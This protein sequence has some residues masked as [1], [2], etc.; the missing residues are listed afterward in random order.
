MLDDFLSPIVD[1][2]PTSIREICGITGE[3]RPLDFVTKAELP[4][5]TYLFVAEGV[6][7]WF[8]YGEL[9]RLNGSFASDDDFLQRPA[10]DQAQGKAAMLWYGTEIRI[11]PKD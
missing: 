10:E 4:I 5:P 7:Y 8:A 6:Y 3:I 11:L 9:T 2:S 1:M